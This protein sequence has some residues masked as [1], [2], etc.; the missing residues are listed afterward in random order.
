M[1][2]RHYRYLPF[3]LSAS[4]MALNVAL[5]VCW[6]ILLAQQSLWGAMTVGIVAFALM[7]LGLSFYLVL[8]IK[9]R[10]LTQRQVNFI[11]SVTHELKS[12]IASLRLYLETLQQRRLTDVQRSEFYETMAAET[13][14]L[15]ALISQLLEVARLDAIGQQDPPE[16]IDLVP[17][18]ESCASAVRLR[19][20]CGERE[21]FKFDLVAAIVPA[22]RMMLEM[23]FGNLLDNAI[24]YGGQPPEVEVHMHVNKHNRVVTQIADNGRGVPPEIRKSIFRLFFRGGEELQRRQKGTGLGLYIARTLVRKLG[25]KIDVRERE[26]RSGSVFEVELPGK[27]A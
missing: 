16:E 7:L 25:G 17:L 22:P 3:T 27:A 10:R 19:R 2:H 15:D 1:R 24:K 13:Q 23:I 20:R 5:M 6:I 8:T 26:G 12:P 4:L 9:E 11:D 14:R 18:L 21:V